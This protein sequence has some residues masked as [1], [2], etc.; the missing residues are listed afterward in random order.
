VFTKRVLPLVALLLALAL[1]AC[2][3]EAG[4]TRSGGPGADVGNRPNPRVEPLPDL[5]GAM[6]PAF[7]TPRIG[8]AIRIISK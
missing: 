3:P 7:G 4:R 8:E 5:H 1:A 2:S 6:D